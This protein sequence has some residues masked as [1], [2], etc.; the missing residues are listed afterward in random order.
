VTLIEIV[1]ALTFLV[2]TVIGAL[3][4]VVGLPGVWLLA[5]AAVACQAIWPGVLGWW[6]VGGAIFA[7]VLGEVVEF[8]ASAAGAKAAGGSRSAALAAVGGGL[9][10]AIAGTVFL[11]VPVVG[12]LV[13][14]VIGAGLGA[15][16]TERGL[17]MKSWSDSGRVARG[18]A[19]GRFVAILVKGAVAVAAGVLLL[20]AALL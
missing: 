12:T 1:L 13:G 14:A 9:E 8:F 18:A 4:V 19:T 3:L 2:L 5:L 15:G 10:G 7:A 17:K 16:L 11:P 20:V 6:V